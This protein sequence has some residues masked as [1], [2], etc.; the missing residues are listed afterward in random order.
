VEGTI[1]QTH[2]LDFPMLW[3]PVPCNSKFLLLE[4]NNPKSELPE[5]KSSREDQIWEWEGLIIQT[6]IAISP[7]HD[8][9]FRVFPIFSEEQQC[10]SEL[11]EANAEEE[12]NSRRVDQTQITDHQS[13]SASIQH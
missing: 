3:S 9:Q 4:N 10:K 12:I 8:H 1:I 13:D 2:M 7:S 11:S 5:N 6:H